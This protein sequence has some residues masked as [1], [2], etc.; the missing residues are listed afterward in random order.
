MNMR[1]KMRNMRIETQSSAK[2]PGGKLSLI[3]HGMNAIVVT[4]PIIA[5]ATGVAKMCGKTASGYG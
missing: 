5:T 2:E 3:I 4:A 1:K